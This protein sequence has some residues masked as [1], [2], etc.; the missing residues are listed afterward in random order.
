MNEKVLHTLEF[1]KIISQLTE[2]ADSAPGKAKCR[3]LRPMEFLSDIDR[4][5]AE[6]EEALSYIFRQSSISFGSNRDFGYTF[7]AL[8]IGSSLSAPELL[9]L[10]SFLDN[11]NRVRAYGMTSKE[12]SAIPEA[13]KASDRDSWK[14]NASEEAKAAKEEEENNVLYDLFDCLCPIPSLVSSIYSMLL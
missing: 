1:D 8:S 7:G 3:A 13:R 6:T 12:N 10:A 11:V 9:H 5:Q 4:A 14:Q 2:H